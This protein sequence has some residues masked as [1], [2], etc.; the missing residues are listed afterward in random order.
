[1][2]KICEWEYT[3]DI[4]QGYARKDFGAYAAPDGG[5]GADPSPYNDFMSKVKTALSMDEQIRSNFSIMPESP[6]KAAL[7]AEYAQVSSIY[8][9]Y[10]QPALEKLKTLFSSGSMGFFPAVIA[11]PW[12]ASTINVA[13]AA[14]IAAIVGGAA[15][16]IQ[17][18]IEKQYTIAKNQETIL[19]NPNLS[20]AQKQTMIESAKGSPIFDLGGF[21]NLTKYALIGGGLFLLYQFSRR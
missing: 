9:Q 3:D 18:I 12:V 10:V 4:L 21:K 13:L 11:L 19:A 16:Y 8:S 20:D 2:P 15:Y 7:Q 6:E 1:M 5:G 14:S 17:M